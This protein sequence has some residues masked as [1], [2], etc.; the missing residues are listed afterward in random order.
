MEQ[1]I[2]EY[3]NQYKVFI[4]NINLPNIAP[5]FDISK[6]NINGSFVYIDVDELSSPTINLYIDEN[7]FQ[8]NERFRKS[9]LFHEFTH[10]FDGVQTFE[11]IRLSDVDKFNKIMA[12]YSEYHASQ[13]EIL[14]NI[15]YKKA[16]PI[17]KKFKMSDKVYFK[18]EFVDIENYIIYP[19]AD[20]SV[21]LD[22][23]KHAYFNLN[24]NEYN[25]KY[26]MAQKS[27]MYY[28]G[29]YNICEKYANKKPHDFFHKF[30]EFEQDV[31]LMY[32]SLKSKDI[33][34]ILGTVDDF[35]LHFMHYFKFK[36]T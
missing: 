16:K 9:I 4:K 3:Y 29:K 18:D 14:C 31:L 8:Y 32:K 12:T 24:D 6:A 30:S 17:T 36:I 34:Q 11:T 27:I 23:N 25:I 21:I 1:K 15:G 19:L 20:A 10:V 33:D 2:Q 28:L 5:V 7:L 35:M 13:I 22:K 26:V